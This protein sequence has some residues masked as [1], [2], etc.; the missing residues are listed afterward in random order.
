MEITVSRKVLSGVNTE[1]AVMYSQQIVDHFVKA[2]EEN[3]CLVQFPVALYMELDNY[4]SQI[5]DYVNAAIEADSSDDSKFTTPAE[6]DAA[7]T[8]A[9]SLTDEVIRQAIKSVSN[10]CF[11]CKIEKPQFDFSN[12]F[13]RLIFDAQ[14]AIDAYKNMFKFRK[15]SVCQYAFFLSYLCVPDLLKLVALILAAIVRITQQI[16]LPRITIAVFIQGI[17]S[18]IIEALVRNVSI[19]AR[20]ALT[21]V[22]CILD[23]IEQIISTLPTP[24]NIRQSSASDL[25]KLGLADYVQYD[26]N[27]QGRLKEVRDTYTSA[28]RG[29]ELSAKTHIEDIFQPLQNTV[30]KTVQ[31]LQD[32]IT[33][34]SGLLNHFQCEPSRSGI[35]VS[36]YL[37]NISELMALANLLR[38]IIRFKSGKAALDKLCNATSEDYASSE[39]AYSDGV[40]SVQ[41][42]GQ[43]IA[44]TIESDIEIITDNDSPI[45]VIIKDPTPKDSSSGLSLWTCNLMDFTNDLNIDKIIER[46]VEDNIDKITPDNPIF[47]IDNSDWSVVIIPQEE[48]TSNNGETE[49]DRFIV[50]LT[51]DTNWNISDHI[52]ETIDVIDKYNPSTDGN[53]TN[54]VKFLPEDVLSGLEDRY[55][56]TQTSIGNRALNNVPK[57]NY[58]NPKDNNFGTNITDNKQAL[59]KTSDRS[60]TINS[61]A[62][63]S[64][65][66]VINLECGSPEEMLNKIGDY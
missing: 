58:V 24:E 12:M 27:L 1:Y 26:T 61:S 14:A 18:A 8:T 32:S 31:S 62:S 28:V 57:L 11:N 25:E 52:K 10:D 29:Q 34:L 59:A 48:S 51:V 41:D 53:I 4:Q 66:V 56:K 37:S 55:T 63:S 44:E 16:N 15:S 39:Y 60:Y 50:P 42:V 33:E 46:F 43:I 54:D 7:S 5:T 36:E 65:S 19:L 21:P 35:S 3:G 20:F 40:M 17:L 6:E 49:Q 22:L 47:P 30:D 64:N 9:S 23:S 13:D 2:L 38:Y 45:S